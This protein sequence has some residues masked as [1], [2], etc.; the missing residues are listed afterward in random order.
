MCI[1]KIESD[2]VPIKLWTQLDTVEEQ[3]LKQLHNI[4]SLP[5]TF[6][7]V[8]VMPD[9]GSGYLGSNPSRR[10]PA[11]RAAVA[12]SPWTRDVVGSN[13]TVQTFA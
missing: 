8:A 6:H 7:H 1:H 10:K 13:P 5:W 2:K 3:A 12:Y 9:C 4:A 11:R